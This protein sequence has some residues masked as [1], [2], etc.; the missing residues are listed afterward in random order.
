[1]V[2]LIFATLLFYSSVYAFENELIDE[3]SPYLLQHAHNPVHWIAYNKE[4]F[5]KAKKEHKPIFL[6]IGYS[7]CHW[8]H[9]MAKESFEN[10]KIAA[11]LN[12]NFISIKVDREEMPHIDTFYQQMHLKIKH[13]SGGWPLSVILD[14]NGSAFFIATYLPSSNKYGVKGLD[15]L[16]PKFSN[17]YKKFPLK[18]AKKVSAYKSM[19]EKEALHVENSIT[20]ESLFHDLEKQYDDL[21]YGFSTAPKFPEASKIELLFVLDSLHV[22]GA[23][24]MALDILDAMALRGMY[25]QV[26]GGFFRYATDAAYEIPHFEKMLYTQAGLIPLY[27]KAYK[28]THK[29][30]YKDVVIETIE[31]LNQ[32]FKANELFYTASDADSNHHEGLYFTFTQKEIDK[33][34]EGVEDKNEIKE[35]LLLDEGENFEKRFHLN[36]Y[37]DKRPINFNTFR[38]KLQ[39]VRKNREYPFIDKK[40]LTSSNA[41]MIEALFSAS[42]IEPKYLIEAKASLEKLLHVSLKKAKL[43]HQ[44][45]IESEVSKEALLE[46]YAYL[47]SALIKAY[48]V[49]MEKSYLQ[50]AEEFQ[51]R[52]IK[53]FYTNGIWYLNQNGKKIK[54]DLRDKYYISAQ[55]KTLQNLLD[56]AL[57]TDSLKY[58]NIALKSLQKL[59][60]NLDTPASNKALLMK[61]YGVILL[62]SNKENLVK[63]RTNIESL[64]YP[65]IHVKKVDNSI[66]LACEIGKCFSYSKVFE[67][68]KNKIEMKANLTK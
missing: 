56:L 44:Y 68:V 51:E 7:T 27:V 63:N 1:M 47:I 64:R 24:S 28:R 36:I 42:R 22:K 32:R 10:E 14:E 57:L 61:N 4:A 60:L 39:A 54:A 13:R 11:I 55:A 16:L 31:M 48:D 58:Q 45:L 50:K 62:K 43:Y 3:T 52:S 17:E 2:K 46:D 40:I 41:M 18:I 65:F 6:S 59:S 25:D 66:Y 29:R 20:K 8:C 38:K 34:L 67:N 30:L 37:S 35:A 53:L 33:A 26:E 12:K 23:L 5:N 15:T 49:T 19:N 9:V 21:Y